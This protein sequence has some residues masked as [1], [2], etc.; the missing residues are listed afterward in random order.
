MSTILVTGANGAFGA[1]CA[2]RLLNDGFDVVS[3]EHDQHPYDTASLIGI[4]DKIVWVR[5]SI[6]DER[7]CKRLIADYCVD[8][9]YHFAA[10]PLVQVATRT[11]VPV[12]QTNFM[13]TV[14]LLEAVKE[15][16]WAGKPIR[17]IH[18]ST[19]KVYGSAGPKPYTEDMPLNG[20]A[21]YDSS[22]AAADLVVRTYAACGFAP[23]VVVARSCN[24]LCQ[25]DLNLGRVLPRTIIPAMRGDSP[26][27]YRTEY[28]REFMFVEDAVDALITLDNGLRDEHDRIHGQAFNIGSGEQR[29]LDQTVTEILKHFPTVSPTWTIPPAISRVEIPFQ[30]LDTT[31]IKSALNWKAATNFETTVKILVDWWRNNWEYLPTAIRTWQAQGWHG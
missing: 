28:L 30:K 24:V 4:R 1:H 18:V 8:A 2:K 20:L 13:G 27:L 12:F 19:D 16:H 7:L 22:K 23:Q 15:N 10:L 25:G 5:G 29:T 31:K 3:I 17:F 9:I 21:I 6:L 11:T 26:V 14:H